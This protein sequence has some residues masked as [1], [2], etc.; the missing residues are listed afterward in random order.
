M[1][2]ERGYA[3]AREEP[4]PPAIPSD[5]H[6]FEQHA[7]LTRR[8]HDFRTMASIYMSHLYTRIPRYL[9]ARGSVYPERRREREREDEKKKEE[10]RDRDRG[11]KILGMEIN[12]T[13]R[14]SSI[15]TARRDDAEEPLIE[16]LSGTETLL[17]DHCRNE[18]KR[19]YLF[20]KIFSKMTIYI[21]RK[22][23][24]CHVFHS[25]QE[26]HTYIYLFRKI[27]LSY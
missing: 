1:K 25:S 16:G 26:A 9:T 21:T 4:F 17:S 27:I 22:I 24:L 2:V 10:K 18:Y 7:F 14:G 6:G 11:D 20:K 3:N 19:H 13:E 15:G 8:C 12:S 23:M 5:L